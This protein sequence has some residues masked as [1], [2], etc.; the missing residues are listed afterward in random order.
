MLLTRPSMPTVSLALRAPSSAKRCET[1]ML[2]VVVRKPVSCGKVPG[3]KPYRLRGRGMG[4]QWDYDAAYRFGP[5]LTDMDE[6][7][8]GEGNHLRMWDALGAHLRDMDGVAGTHF[9]V[10][11]PNAR[12]VSVVGEFNAW[13]SKSVVS[14]TAQN[15]TRR[16]RLSAWG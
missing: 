4:G 3:G 1:K 5:V 6:Y 13:S 11:A 8:L 7:L 9:A 15:G 2:A 10:W 16:C 14:S 12:R